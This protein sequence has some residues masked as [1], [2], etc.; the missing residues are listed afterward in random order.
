MASFD[1]IGSQLDSKPTY[2]QIHENKLK[3]WREGQKRKYN[4]NK[5][6][7]DAKDVYRVLNQSID[8]AVYDTAEKFRNYQNKFELGYSSKFQN[9]QANILQKCDE[10]TE[11]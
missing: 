1:T 3:Y 5:I 6:E 7:I 11:K 9:Y 8:Q 4:N 10:S 2:Q